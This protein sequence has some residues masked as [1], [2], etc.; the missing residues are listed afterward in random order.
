MKVIGFKRVDFVTPEKDT[1]KG[2]K[3]FCTYSDADDKNLIGTA[4]EDFFITDTKAA[5]WMPKIGDEVEIVY[6][7]YGKIDKIRLLKAAA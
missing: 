6:N 3:V 5:G 2:H 7:K 4:C 1:I